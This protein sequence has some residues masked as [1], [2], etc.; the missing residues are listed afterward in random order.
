MKNVNPETVLAIGLMIAAV[1]VSRLPLKWLGWWE[2]PVA[3]LARLRTAAIFGAAL[4][5]LV[6]RALLLPLYP[7]PAP[8]VHDEFSYLLGADTL[9]HGRLANPAHPFWVHFESMHILTQPA[10]ATVFPMGQ[11]AALAIGQVLFGHPWPGV[12]LSV[13]VMCGAVCWML[14]GWLPPRWALLGALLLGIRL[15]VSS[16]WMN[17]YWGGC[18]A[19]TGGALVLGALPRIRHSLRSRDALLLGIGLAILANSRSFEGAVLAAIVAVP[20]LGWLFKP[21]KEFALKMSRAVVPLSLALI[22][23]AAATM[24]YF[25]RVTGKAWVPPYV[26]YRSTMTMAPHFIWQSPRREPLYNNRELRNFY[27]YQEVNE[28][29]T[30]RSQPFRDFWGKFNGYWR[31]YIGPILTIPLA[32]LP[33]LWRDRRAAREVLLMAIAFP[34]ALVGQVWHNVHY[35]APATGLVTLLVILCLRRLRLWRPRGLPTGLFLV[36]TIPLASVAMLFIQ[37]GA[38][39]AHGDQAEGASWRWPSPGGIVRQRVLHE[40]EAIPGKHLVLTRYSRSHELGDE[41]VYNGADI[42]GSR[43]I[44]ARE[45]DRDS[46]ERL[47]RY[48]AGRRIWLVEPDQAAPSAIDYRAAPHRPMPFVQIGAPGIEVLRSREAVRSAVIVRAEIYHGQP[49]SCDAWNFLFTDATGVAGPVVT[50]DCY[51]TADRGREVTFEHWFSW[52][53]QQR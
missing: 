3:Q 16:Y 36:R 40:L 13:G 52:L 25:A 8:R 18:V 51:G 5:P 43:V 35:A 29:Q 34:L 2:K 28:Y 1:F 23:A 50:S 6:L 27:V 12:W 14:Q 53:L 7:A 39:S 9:A 21:R 42:D 41:W 31:F 48:F 10:Y 38:R 19:A 37:I 20:L 32:A 49:L 26:L 33:W 4:L 11:S 17:S 44:W 46:N 47:M 15:G 24:Y 22:V 30:V 45:L